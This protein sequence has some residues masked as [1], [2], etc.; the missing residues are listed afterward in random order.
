MIA[1]FLLI[2]AV[3]HVKDE[4]GNKL[5][6]QKVINYIQQVLNNFK[7]NYTNFS[8]LLIFGLLKYKI[9]FTEK[10]TI[11]ALKFRIDTIFNKS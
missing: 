6:D 1:R 7:L 9:L 11:N 5:T 4:H 3:F 8:V 2:P 10:G